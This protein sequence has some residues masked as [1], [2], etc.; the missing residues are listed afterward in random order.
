MTAR[1]GRRHSFLEQRG[2]QHKES[3]ETKE[4]VLKIEDLYFSYSSP[5]KN[6]KNQKRKKF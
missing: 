5:G 4:E 6:G 2:K 1:S 3:G